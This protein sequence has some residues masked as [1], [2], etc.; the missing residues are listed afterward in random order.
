MGKGAGDHGF[1]ASS[2]VPQLSIQAIDS[3]LPRAKPTF[4][5]KFFQTLDPLL[6]LSFFKETDIGRGRS[7]F[8]IAASGNSY[9]LIRVCP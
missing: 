4:P 9:F 8:K 3:T 1:C 7:Q 5:E 6:E 2:T